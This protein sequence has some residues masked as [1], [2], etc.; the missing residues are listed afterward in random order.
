MLVGN[1]Q[2][3]LLEQDQNAYGPNNGPQTLIPFEEQEKISHNLNRRHSTIST[4]DAYDQERSVMAMHL[5]MGPFPVNLGFNINKSEKS[6]LEHEHFLLPT[7]S[8]GTSLK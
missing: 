7:K 2:T 8:K 4:R 6:P 3:H 5:E 1:G